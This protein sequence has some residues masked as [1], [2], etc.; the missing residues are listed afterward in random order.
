MV[1]PFSSQIPL[2]VLQKWRALAEQRRA[3]FLELYMS[4][5][6][7]HYYAEQDFVA[8]MREA[9]QLL[10]MWNGLAQ[11]PQD[12]PAGSTRMHDPSVSDMIDPMSGV[13]TGMKNVLA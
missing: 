12:I 10:E 9:I 4:G 5:R 8:R 1:E 7:K 13:V 2:E 3:H 11:V 6:W